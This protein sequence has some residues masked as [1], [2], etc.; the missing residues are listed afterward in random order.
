MGLIDGLHDLRCTVLCPFDRL[1]FYTWKGVYARHNERR[2]EGNE[3]N[4]RT[5]E[6]R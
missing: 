1:I 5:Q 2:K 6:R 3:G 4:Q